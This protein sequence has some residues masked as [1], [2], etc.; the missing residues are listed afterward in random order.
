MGRIL[1]RFPVSK[2]APP[3]YML[4]AWQWTRAAHASDD[5]ATDTHV[6]TR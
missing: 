5:T 6:P 1:R 2:I 4:P 3:C